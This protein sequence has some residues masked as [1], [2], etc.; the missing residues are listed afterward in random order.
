[1]NSQFI[2]CLLCF[3]ENFKVKIIISEIIYTNFSVSLLIFKIAPK[4]LF[5]QDFFRT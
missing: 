2:T 5:L 1:M 3:N 4:S